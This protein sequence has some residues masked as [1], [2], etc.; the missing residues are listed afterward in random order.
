MKPHGP[1]TQ[2]ELLTIFCK[3]DKESHTTEPLSMHAHSEICRGVQQGS[4]RR[5]KELGVVI[6]DPDRGDHKSQFQMLGRHAGQSLL[7]N[8][9]KPR[10]EGAWGLWP[11]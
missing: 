5:E 6:P 1:I 3:H 9:R 2:I 4:Q 10:W 11:V 8:Q 7:G